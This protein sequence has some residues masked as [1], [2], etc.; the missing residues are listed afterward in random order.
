MTRRLETC[1]PTTHSSLK[2]LHVVSPKRHIYNIRK[3]GRVASHK[4]R[5]QHM[6][7]DKFTYPPL[8]GP[9]LE[10]GVG[11]GGWHVT[12]LSSLKINRA[13]SYLLPIV[14]IG[15]HCTYIPIGLYKHKNK[16][17]NRECFGEIVEN[18]SNHYFHIIHCLE[19]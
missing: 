19:N 10:L 11:F 3:W 2:F 15:T 4:T 18:H 16:K 5:T 9:P 13:L 17:N 7:K 12:H 6:S 14:P 1:Q 8:I